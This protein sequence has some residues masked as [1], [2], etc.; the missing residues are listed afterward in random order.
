MKHPY[1]KWKETFIVYLFYFFCTKVWLDTRTA[2]EVDE[3]LSNPNKKAQAERV[4]NLCGLP[5]STYFSS[6]KIK[7][8]INNV[9]AVSIAIQED[10]CLV[11]TVDS[12]IIWNLT[13]GKSA[14]VHVTD[15][16]NAS[17]TMLMNI[18]TLE[19]DAYLCE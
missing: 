1:T 7:W 11:G 5:I 8:L 2:N 19:W 15:V 14:G 6:L 3:I 16:T 12:W 9:P 17:R 18:E 13:G 4:R 10:R